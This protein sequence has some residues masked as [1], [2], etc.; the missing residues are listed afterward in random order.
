MKIRHICE[1]F[2]TS[3]T[4]YG[5]YFEI[6]SDPSHRE[7]LSAA[8]KRSGLRFIIDFKEEI[9]YAFSEDLLHQKAAKK[10]KVPYHFPNWNNNNY[11]FGLGF[12]D[13]TRIS[14][15]IDNLDATYQRKQEIMKGQQEWLNRFI[16]FTTYGVDDT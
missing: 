9:F 11:A 12:L 15:I 14:S 1:E 6:F 16:T 7:L 2:A 10:L 5:V 13:G 8:S 4:F 3:T